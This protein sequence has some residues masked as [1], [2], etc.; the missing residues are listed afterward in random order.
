MLPLPTT[1]RPR[2][3]TTLKRSNTKL[4]PALPRATTP[5]SRSITVRKRSRLK[6]KEVVPE[7]QC[8][9][10]HQL[11]SS[12]CNRFPIMGKYSYFYIEYCINSIFFFYLFICLLIFNINVY[13]YL[14]FSQQWR[15]AAVGCCIVDGWVDRWFSDVSLVWRKH[16]RNAAAFLHNLRNDQFLHRCLR[17]LHH[18]S[19]GVLYHN[20]RC[21]EPLH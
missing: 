10:C 15:R 6:K 2:I 16:N 18:L 5:T 11:H 8:P 3:T 13:I 1:P 9:I 12:S 17:V 4:Q 21:P 19:T 20:L 14:L 7:L